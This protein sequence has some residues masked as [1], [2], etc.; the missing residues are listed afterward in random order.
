MTT[1]LAARVVIFL[2]GRRRRLGRPQRDRWRRRSCS[3]PLIDLAFPPTDAFRRQMDR[4]RKFPAPAKHPHRRACEATNTR[5]HVRPTEKPI[6]SHDFLFV[7]A[8]TYID[9]ALVGGGKERRKK[10][11]PR[12]PLGIRYFYEGISLSETGCPLS[13]RVLTNFPRVFLVRCRLRPTR[14]SRVVFA[15]GPPSC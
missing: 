4:R 7:Q 15:S 8:Q 13:E 14:I 2:S 9:L 6:A 10:R 12:N 5:S 1:A 11:Y 3:H